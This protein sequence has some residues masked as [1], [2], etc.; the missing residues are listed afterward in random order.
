[1]AYQVR[2][3]SRNYR[4]WKKWHPHSKPRNLCR[5]FWTS[6]YQW[7]L[8]WLVLGIAIIAAATIFLLVVTFAWLCGF[9]FRGTAEIDV[10][11]DLSYGYKHDLYNIKISGRRYSIAPWEVIV[12]LVGAWAA[13]KVGRFIVELFIHPP[14]FL[15]DRSFWFTVGSWTL[16]CVGLLGLYG[17]YRFF[18]S[19]LLIEY[20]RAK[21]DKWCPDVEVV[22]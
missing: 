5:Y 18:T 13:Y 20:L 14:T 2:R 7:T 22:D 21:R 4:L 6:V 17:L 15:F 9:R 10:S 12:T 16:I 11:D 8:R 19:G 1:M 3:S